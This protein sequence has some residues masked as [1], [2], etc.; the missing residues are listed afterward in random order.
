ML[1]MWCGEETPDGSAFCEKCGH[2]F[3]GIEGAPDS[4]D[5]GTV[6]DPENVASEEE[7]FEQPDDEPSAIEEELS[8]D[9]AIAIEEELSAPAI[10]EDFPSDAAPTV[11]EELSSGAAPATE[12][13]F[14]DDAAPETLESYSGTLSFDDVEASVEPARRI[15]VGGPYV[16]PPSPPIQPELSRGR[17]AI[18]ATIAVLF[19]AAVILLAWASILRFL[20]L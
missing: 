19:A 6:L 16:E 7:G 12:E 2:A 13:E 17:I 9:I 4:E 10:E 8:D 20:G 18:V 5:A 1:C 3:E 15:S 14:S 11:E